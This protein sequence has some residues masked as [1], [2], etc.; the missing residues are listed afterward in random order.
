MHT[1]ENHGRFPHPSNAACMC[2]GASAAVQ[3]QA[4][5]ICIV[6]SYKYPFYVI[7][8]YIS[9]EETSRVGQLQRHTSAM[10]LEE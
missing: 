6:N 4:L 3:L 10:L 2:G 9:P 1:A 8:G 7:R 5:L